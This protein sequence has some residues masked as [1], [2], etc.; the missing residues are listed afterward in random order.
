MILSIEII[1]RENGW[2]S[3]RNFHG[4]GQQQGFQPILLRF[5]ILKIAISCLESKDKPAYICNVI[6]LTNSY[7]RQ[8][9][10]EGASRQRSK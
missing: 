1:C 7:S 10:E 9:L 5:G 4:I 2:T 8:S 3:G 6:V